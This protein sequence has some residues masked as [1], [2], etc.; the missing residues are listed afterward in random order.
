MDF[1]LCF[2][3]SMLIENVFSVGAMK[4]ETLYARFVIRYVTNLL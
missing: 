2:F 4:R 3:T 1:L